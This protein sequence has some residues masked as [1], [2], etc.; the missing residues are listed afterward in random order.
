M[1]S[2][3][4]WRHLGLSSR[5]LSQS[6]AA[7]RWISISNAPLRVRFLTA[8]DDFDTVNY[9]LDTLREGLLNV[10]DNPPIHVRICG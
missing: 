8:S 1:D 10:S 5:S 3:P 2:T 4:H 6:K 7:H 9:S